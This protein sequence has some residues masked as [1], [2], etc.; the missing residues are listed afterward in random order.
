[1]GIV[2]AILVLLVVFFVL[3]IVARMITSGAKF[4]TTKACPDC[5]ERVKSV[6][7]KCRHCGHEFAA[8]SA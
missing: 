8:D 3:A 4:A 5:A 2:G 7:A 1:M 6:A